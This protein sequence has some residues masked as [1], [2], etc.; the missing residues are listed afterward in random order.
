MTA[1]AYTEGPQAFQLATPPDEST[2]QSFSSVGEYRFVPSVKNFLNAKS[3]LAQSGKQYMFH[4]LDM[5]Q[6]ITFLNDKT[7]NDARP[8]LEFVNEITGDLSKVKG[9]LPSSETEIDTM[10]NRFRQLTLKM[11]SIPAAYKE[12]FERK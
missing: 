11:T 1:T 3:R 12:L 2:Y 7:N 6:V 10:R 4:V 5:P 8:S 9:L